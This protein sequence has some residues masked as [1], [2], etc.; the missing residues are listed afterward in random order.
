MNK[1]YAGK[2]CLDY[3]HGDAR[4]PAEISGHELEVFAYTDVS[5]HLRKN[6]YV[7]PGGKLQKILH[8]DLGDLISDFVENSFPPYGFSY[9]HGKARFPNNINKERIFL[10]PAELRE[11]EQYADLVLNNRRKELLYNFKLKKDIIMV[12]HPLEFRITEYHSVGGKR[13]AKIQESVI[14]RFIKKRG[15][16]LPD[17]IYFS[18]DTNPL[19]YDPKFH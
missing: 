10:L 4:I 7:V 5:W 17:P 14:P 19:I 6:I 2:C 12:E 16:T 18:F 15:A 9:T 1:V 8:A 3:L 11:I 13:I